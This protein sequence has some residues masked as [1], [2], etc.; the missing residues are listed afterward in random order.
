M[1]VRVTFTDPRDVGREVTLMLHF[2]PADKEPAQ[3]LVCE[4]GAV[5][6]IVLTDTLKSPLLLNVTVC[7]GLVVPRLTL[8]KE[9]LEGE[10]DTPAIPTP[11]KFTVCVGCCGSLLTSVMVPLCTPV[12]VGTNFTVRAQLPFGSKLLSVVQLPERLNWLGDAVRLVM[13]S[14]VF[15]FGLLRVMLLVAFVLI[16][17]LPKEML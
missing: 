8:P 15:P 16:A 7:I 9:T 13:V 6:V 17:T 12:I 4:N 11:I 2:P 10:S 1:T 14:F 3:L 5:A